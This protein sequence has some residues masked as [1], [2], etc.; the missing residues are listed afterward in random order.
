[1][2]KYRKPKKFECYKCQTG[3]YLV[4]SQMSVDYVCEGCGKWQ[5]WELD[6]TYYP[7]GISRESVK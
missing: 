3:D 7:I 1:M 2:T 5:N 4:L 6:D